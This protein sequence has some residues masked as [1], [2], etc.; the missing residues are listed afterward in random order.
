LS[1]FT[2]AAA[3]TINV[4]YNQLDPLLRATPGFENG[5][6]NDPAT[7]YSPFPGNIN[8]LVFS[9]PEYVAVL[10][11]TGGIMPEFVNPK[12]ADPE[13]RT[14]FKKPTRLECMMQDF[15]VVLGAAEAGDGGDDD[16]ARVGFTT[17]PADLCFSPVK[18]AA[19]D[20][21][22]LQHASG[23]HPGTASSGEADQYRAW[24]T[25]LRSLGCRV[26]EA[27]EETHLGVSVVP[28][29]AVVFKPSF[30][31]CPGELRDRFPRPEQIFISRRSTLIVKGGGDATIV[32][33][34][35]DGALIVDCPAG[36][37]LVVDRPDPVANRGWVRVRC[38]AS[39]GGSEV[40][41]MRGYRLERL[42]TEYITA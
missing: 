42:E 19:A 25:L 5:D 30:C 34:H 37:A 1:F 18:N 20:G 31:C 17:V 24:R 29:P 14:V 9:L 12:Y 15:P 40:I 7:G 22:A 21:A 11:R 16:S 33:L 41:K 4:E 26:E 3:S 10:E 36:T 6:V 39:E 27:D 8:Q 2:T 32:R 38:D 35:L 28:G 13:T 23:T